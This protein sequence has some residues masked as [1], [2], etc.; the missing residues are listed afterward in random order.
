M[1]KFAEEYTAAW[2]SQEPSRVS[3]FFAEDGILFVNGSPADGRQA[4][5]EVAAG[6]MSGFPD[7]ELLMDRLEINPEGA[8]YHWTFTGTNTGPGGTGNA[9]RFSGCEEWTFGADGLIAVSQ[10]HFDDEDYQR[11]LEDNLAVI[12]EL[13]VSAVSHQLRLLRD[14]DLVNARR[15]GRMVYYSL[16]DEHVRTLMATGVEHASER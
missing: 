1:N 2:N 3:A 8:R 7:M 14:R 12:A 16:A 13:S 10:G 11:Q 15:D 9:V 5:T 6:F 4:I